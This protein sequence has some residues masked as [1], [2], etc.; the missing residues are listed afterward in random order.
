MAAEPTDAIKLQA[1][2][3]SLADR[4]DVILCER[5]IETALNDNT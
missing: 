4:I 5:R 2:A 3:H 1:A